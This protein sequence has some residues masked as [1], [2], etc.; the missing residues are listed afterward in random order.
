MKREMGGTPEFQVWGKIVI[1]KLMLMLLLLLLIMA[2]FKN[3]FNK[4]IGRLMINI[5]FEFVICRYR[6]LILQRQI[7]CVHLYGWVCVCV[8]Y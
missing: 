5:L 2:V 4:F 3:C 7:S 8:C 6:P 1:T